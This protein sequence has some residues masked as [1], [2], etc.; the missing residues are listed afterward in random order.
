MACK[1]SITTRS[2]H[3]APFVLRGFIAASRHYVFGAAELG[4]RH[5]KINYVDRFK[6]F[7]AA[8]EACVLHDRGKRLEKYFTEDATYWNV[9]G[10]DPRI[11]SR[12]AI[13]DYL[14]NDVSNNDRRF[15]SR[16]LEATSEPAVAGN[17][18]SRQWR[19]SYTLAGAPDLVVEG[20]ARYEFK[21]GLIRALEEEIT[22]ESKEKYAGWM[23][24]FGQRLAP[25]N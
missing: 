15:D 24:E 12:E 19:C 9:G 4:V 22:P 17:Q 5:S 20:V 23:E 10:P 16:I 25:N 21:G 11:S 18:L 2:S 8:F 6:S 14:R 1:K 7:A 13:I 3:W